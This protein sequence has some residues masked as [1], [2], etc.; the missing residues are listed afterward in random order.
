MDE[1]RPTPIPEDKSTWARG[2]SVLA[3]NNAKTM[4]QILED[5]SAGHLD[6]DN[7]YSKSVGDLYASCTDEAGI[8]SRGLAE[9]APELALVE[10]VKDAPSLA[11][12]IAHQQTLA[13]TPIFDFESETDQKDARQTIGAFRQAG[14]TLPDRDY[15]VHDDPKSVAMRAKMQAHVEAMFVLAGETPAKAKTDA[16]TVL[17]I[18]TKLAGPQMPRVD[19]RDP[20]KV[21]HRMDRKGA[22][23]ARPGIPV[24]RVL[25]GARLP[26]DGRHQRDGARVREGAHRDPRE[27]TDGELAH[28][29]AVAPGAHGRAVAGARRSSRRTS[30]LP[31]SC[32]SP[33]R[34][35]S[36]RA[37]GGACAWP[38]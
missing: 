37:G 2:F 17:A 8:E 19:Q 29:L 38:T 11:K 15:Y 33:A 18:E 1:S 36:S 30:P 24:G 14:L 27:R 25:H 32:C 3:E 23:G 10:S 4:R 34:R 5:A 22:R 13:I 21:Y 28:V 7:P 26:G 6:G 16:A 12:E 31:S 9:L 20:D 35:R